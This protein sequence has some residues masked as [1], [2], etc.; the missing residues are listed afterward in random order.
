M[1]GRQPPKEQILQVSGMNYQHHP[2]VPLLCFLFV[3]VEREWMWP[4]KLKRRSFVSFW[5]LASPVSYD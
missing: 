2:V 5:I 1:L 3:W 4:G